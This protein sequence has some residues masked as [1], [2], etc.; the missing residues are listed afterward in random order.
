MA[1]PAILDDQQPLVD[2]IAFAFLAVRALRSYLERLEELAD[3]VTKK[4]AY[5]RT[6]WYVRTRKH[7]HFL[8]RRSGPL[9]YRVDRDDNSLVE[10]AKYRW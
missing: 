7:P 4:Q 10:D 8:T 3:T 5:M 6:A 1:L 2:C 9:V